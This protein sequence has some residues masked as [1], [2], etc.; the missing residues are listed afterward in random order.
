ML[1]HQGGLTFGTAIVFEEVQTESNARTKFF[2]VRTL[3]DVPLGQVKWA[4]SIG[5]THTSGVQEYRFHPMTR[6]VFDPVSL[7]EIAEFCE[8]HTRW[9][10]H[11]RRLEAKRRSTE[12]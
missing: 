8:Y 10:K 5:V 2:A 9:H 7:R 11:R 1:N 3:H 4:N 12:C 6:S